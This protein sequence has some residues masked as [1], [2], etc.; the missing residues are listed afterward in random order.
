MERVKNTKRVHYAALVIGCLLAAAVVRL[1]GTGEKTKPLCDSVTTANLDNTA[2]KSTDYILAKMNDEYYQTSASDEFGD[3][4]S[5]DEW[6]L[7]SEKPDGEV[8]VSLR[9]AELYVLEI[10]D[11]GYAAVYDGYA[12]ADTIS[13]AF[14]AIPETTMPSVTSYLRQYGIPHEMGDGTIGPG[15]FNH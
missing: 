6:K 14:Y 15:T 2:R 1:I 13:Y 8:C 12:Q 7:V 10:L 5:F 4:F 3:T 9:F 11:C